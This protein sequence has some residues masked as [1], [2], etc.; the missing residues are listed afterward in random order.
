MGVSGKH[1]GS[2]MDR[3]GPCAAYERWQKTP[4]YQERLKK[5]AAR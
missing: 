3:V 4:E 5:T 2:D 1:V